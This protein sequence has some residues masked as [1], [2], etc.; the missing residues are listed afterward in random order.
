MRLLLQ[1]SHGDNDVQT[2]I[3]THEISRISCPDDKMQ[4]RVYYP[5]YQNSFHFHYHEFVELAV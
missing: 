4:L 2:T 5:K 1:L 3:L